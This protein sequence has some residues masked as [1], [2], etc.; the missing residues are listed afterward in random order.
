[1]IYSIEEDANGALVVIEVA[2]MLIMATFRRD[3]RDLAEETR[4]RLT[5]RKL[6]EGRS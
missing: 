3:L 1:M 2:T 6:V 5:I 4:D